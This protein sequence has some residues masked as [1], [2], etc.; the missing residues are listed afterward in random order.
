MDEGWDVREPSYPRR[1]L[2]RGLREAFSFSSG[3]GRAYV[4]SG[5]PPCPLGLGACA[6][7]MGE[8]VAYNCTLFSVFNSLEKNIPEQAI[9]WILLSTTNQVGIVGS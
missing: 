4:G 8:G 7:V 6:G 3:V 2:V 1:S 5:L 9:L